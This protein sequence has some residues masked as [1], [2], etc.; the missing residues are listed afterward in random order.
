MKFKHT[1]SLFFLLLFYMNTSAQQWLQS[2]YLKTKADSNLGYNFYDIQRAFQFYETDMSKAKE[3]KT[4]KEKG[5]GEIEGSFPGKNLYKRW[6]WYNEQRVYPTGVFP[7]VEMV[8]KEYQEFKSKSSLSSRASKG[9]Q[10]TNANWMNLAAP[11]VLTGSS[12]G[13]GRINCMAFMP[14]NNNTILIG[15]ACGGVWKTVDGGLNWSVLN[16]DN[17]PSLSIASIAIDPTDTNKIYIATGDNF[18]GIP[19]FFKT[20]QGHFSA[21]IFKSTDGGLT[22][23]PTGLSAQQTDFLYPQQL[24]IDPV[25]PSTLLL[26]SS[27]GIW[28][29]TTSAMGAWTNVRVGSFYNIEFNPLDRNI[30]YATNGQGLWR[31]NDNGVTWTYKG[32]GY[33]NLTGGRVSL[34]IT[35][36]DTSY[37]YLWGPTL[38]VKRSV[39]SGTS[40]S[41][42]SNP[43]ATIL[44][45][46][47]Y[48][49]AIAVSPLNKLKV[50]VGGGNASLR[51]S[52]GGFNWVPSSTWSNHLNADYIHQDI[53]KFVY[54]PGG[55]K[56][57]A[58]TDGGIFVTTNDGVNWTNLSNGLQIAEIYRITSSP[59][60]KDTIYYG[61]QD[62]A[63]N[64]WN[65]INNTSTQVLSSDGMQSLIDYTNPQ[66]VFA[67]KPYGDLKK[68]IDGGQN[69]VLASPGQSPW[70]APYVMNQLNPRTMYIGTQSGVQKSYDQATFLSWFIVSA[71]MV[72]SVT[73]VAVTKADTNYVYASKFGKIVKSVDGGAN[74]TNITAG[75]PLNANFLIPAGIS[76]IVVSD[77]DPLKIWI[78]LSGYSSG[79]K[80]F[81]TVDGGMNWINYSGTLPNIPVNCIV[82]VH[83]SNDQVIIGTDFG[84]F[85]RDATLPDWIPYNT[86][87]PNVIVNHLDIQ[88]SVMKLRAG[89]YGRGLWE[90]DLPVI[91]GTLPVEL[92]SFSGEYNEENECNDLHWITASEINADYFD[93]MKSIDASYFTAIGRVNASGNSSQEHSYHFEDCH[94][95][96][97]VN[98]YYLSQVDYD[99]K[100]TR[101]PVISIHGGHANDFITLYPNP[102][103]EKIQFLFLE[104]IDAYD[105]EL[106]DVSGSQIR[107]PYDIKEIK[108]TNT[109]S[110]SF[111]LPGI[112][113]LKIINSTTKKSFYGK[114]VK[115]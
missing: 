69:F 90:T 98:Y 4:V 48:D 11:L 22:W 12:A 39:N 34:A 41:A 102:A 14:G 43:D 15:T 83:G 66:I 110:V 45:Y 38:G 104:K 113:F 23:N 99:G 105:L 20:L 68:S 61:C 29:N 91:T 16:T 82:H 32:G 53:K 24:L 19:N 8:L 1:S 54:E 25:V 95:I 17:L 88:Y 65:G 31:S 108:E 103:N 85:Y 33:S 67:C 64:L 58:L 115:S 93:V 101:S 97:G 7:S 92:L 2:P 27:T 77:T 71:G 86:G 57:Y 74:W 114:F 6:E 52:N 56:L 10:A 109:M 63:T 75:L 13:T 87:L 76:Y 40:F 107:I 106:F 5:T 89:T 72:D 96:N 80:V 26:V 49:R 70:I 21:G 18:A 30:V 9:N 81:V 35:P 51:S 73:S 50:Q 44:P 37:I 62:A 111:L 47:Y 59:F 79:N 3:E 112:Y 42:I 84:V 28:R 94:F 100:T 78:A 55:A 36:I 60:N 46:G